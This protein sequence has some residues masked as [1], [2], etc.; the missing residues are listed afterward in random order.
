MKLGDDMRINEDLLEWS[1]EKICNGEYRVFKDK[2]YSG[3]K[4]DKGDI[5]IPAIYDEVRQPDEN[6][7]VKVFIGKEKIVN[8]YTIG[9]LTTNNKIVLDPTNYYGAHYGSANRLIA[10][11][12]D[13]SICEVFR[14]EKK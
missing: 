4:S 11:R 12:K 6:G 9:C 14:V 8:S 7:L 10:E 1:P 5:V 2:E 13:K 3:L